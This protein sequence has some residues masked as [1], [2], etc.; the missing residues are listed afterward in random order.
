MYMYHNGKISMPFI[1]VL[2]SKTSFDLDNLALVGLTYNLLDKS[3]YGYTGFSIGLL[4]DKTY[5]LRTTCKERPV[6][7]VTPNSVFIPVM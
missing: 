6:V 1:E 5:L 3:I 4:I 7:Y 2:V